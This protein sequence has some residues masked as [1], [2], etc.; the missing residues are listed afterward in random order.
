MLRA[1]SCHGATACRP[2]APPAC[3]VRL[4]LRPA[5]GHSRS[6]IQA[7]LAPHAEGGDEPADRG[8]AVAAAAIVAAAAVAPAVAMAAVAAAAAIVAVRGRL[9]PGVVASL[10]PHGVE[11]DAAPVVAGASPHRRGVGCRGE[12]AVPALVAASA[13]AAWLVELGQWG[14]WAGGRVGVEKTRSRGGDVGAGAYSFG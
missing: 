2:P 5:G 12:D 8:V 10:P 4:E 11:W 7:K 1:I 6:H 13:S 14:G 3:S 9:T